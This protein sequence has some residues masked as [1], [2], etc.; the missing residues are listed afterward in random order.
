MRFAF[1]TTLYP[2][3][4]RAFYSA[5]PGLQTRP[6]AEQKTAID[7]DGFAWCGAL[8]PAFAALEYR[9]NSF[10]ANV[11]PLQRAWAMEHGIS[12]PASGWLEEVA[13]RQVEAFGTEVLWVDALAVFRDSWI[14]RARAVCR[15]LRLVLGYTGVDVDDRDTIRACDAMFCTIR[16]FVDKFRSAG[17]RAFLFRHAFNPK[18]NEGLSNTDAITGELLFTG[19]MARG[20]GSHLERE[21]LIEA[22]VDLLPMAIHCPESELSYWRDWM[23]TGLRLGIY[24]FMKTLRNAGIPDRVLRRVPS[25]GRAAYW[26]SMPSRQIN[27]YLWSR[28]KSPLY[29]AEM[30]A[31]IRSHAVTLNI[32]IDMA[33]T[34]AGNCRLFETTG[35]GGCLLTDWKANLSEMFELDR[36]VAVFRSHEEC[37]EKGRWLLEHPI[38]RNALARAGQERVLREHTFAHRAV[39]LDRLIHYELL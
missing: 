38:E 17:M 3:Y 37:F 9:V 1:L 28:M 7:A 31:A 8:E 22:M 10:Y 12:W 33:R 23:E 19:S 27:P 6:Y 5:R 13:L 34:E 4:I 16:Y 14:Q 11:M 30:Y 39:E 35:A 2:G 18:A 20:A 32:H 26:R 15:D 29:G 21:R 36:E 24:C 25:I